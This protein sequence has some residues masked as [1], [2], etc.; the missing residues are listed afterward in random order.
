MGP[1]WGPKGTPSGPLWC[2]IRAL[3]RGPTRPLG[4]PIGALKGPNSGT[5]GGAHP[6]GTLKGS[7]W[8]P[9]GPLGGAIVLH[10]EGPLKAEKG[11]VW[12]GKE[13]RK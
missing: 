10:R 1:L 6:I 9:Q 7:H 2:P 8:G 3:K 13:R 12:K 4:G 11:A 5:T